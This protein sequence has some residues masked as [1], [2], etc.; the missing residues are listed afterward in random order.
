[1]REAFRRWRYAHPA[2]VLILP[3]MM[4]LVPVMWAARDSIWSVGLLVLFNILAILRFPTLSLI[5]RRRLQ[6]QYPQR[7]LREELGCLLSKNGKGIG[8]GVLALGELEVRFLH[9]SGESFSIDASQIESVALP[10]LDVQGSVRALQIRTREETEFFFSVHDLDL[11]HESIESW[12]DRGGQ[13]KGLPGD[14]S[15]REKLS[16]VSGETPVA[17]R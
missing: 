14:Q 17:G 8:R 2:L 15:W 6:Q 12:L 10:S 13:G 4:A 7:W 16:S 11:W 5:L 9:P 3:V 1:M